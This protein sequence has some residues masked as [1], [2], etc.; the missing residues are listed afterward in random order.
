[1][2]TQAVL[3]RAPAAEAKE[4]SSAARARARPGANAVKASLTPSFVAAIPVFARGEGASANSSAFPRLALQRKLAIGAVDDPLEHEADRV[5]DKVMRM[6]E[7]AAV[8]TQSG[9]PLLRRK[10]ACEDSSKPCAACSAEREEAVLQRKAAGAVARIE[11]PPIVHEVL[12]SPGQ[13]LDAATRAFFEPRFGYDFSGVRVH[14][15]ARARQS[16]RSVDAQAYAVGNDIVFGAES[17]PAGS[18]AGRVLMAHELIHVV[19]QDGRPR[20]VQRQLKGATG[21]AEPDEPLE[22]ALEREERREAIAAENKKLGDILERIEEQRIEE[23]EKEDPFFVRENPRLVQLRA[24]LN[25]EKKRLPEELQKSWIKEAKSLLKA[26]DQ[27]SVLE[28]ELKRLENNRQLLERSAPQAVAAMETM[29]KAGRAEAEKDV[30]ER[31]AS[32]KAISQYMEAQKDYITEKERYLR[33]MREQLKLQGLAAARKAGVTTETAVPGEPAALLQT[34][35]LLQTMIE[36]SRLLEPYLTG[37]RDIN[38]RVPAKFKVDGPDAFEAAKRAAHL[39]PFESGIGGFYDRA[40]D[41]IHLPQKAH[42]AEALHEAIHKYSAPHLRNMCHTLNE[43]V[44]QYFADAI[45]QEQG[46]P[47]A[48]RVAYQDYVDCATKL[49]R[50]FGFDNVARLYFLGL[51]GPKGLMDAVR[52]CDEYCD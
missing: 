2:G 34:T 19:Q 50:Q 15:D 6:P 35:T 41:T 20:V 47:K 44:T 30:E 9:A 43:G 10:C 42:F 13:P 27:L 36:A 18:R 49:M 32:I 51:F 26:E 33:E 46:L 23:E 12:R 11:A 1:M 16:A 37:K 22:V 5:A 40:R 8:A 38:L 7:P 39:S 4:G 31:L 28:D 29:L 52:K 48:G 21:A 3:I 45:L 24:Q 25:E 17:P 14:A